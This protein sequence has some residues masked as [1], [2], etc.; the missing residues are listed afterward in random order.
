MQR[1]RLIAAV[2]ILGVYLLVAGIFIIKGFSGTAAENWTQ[3]M[4]VFN[5][6]GALATTAAGVLFGADIQQGNV[7]EANRT[8]VEAAATT[9]RR[10]E[11]LRATLVALQGGQGIADP[12]AAARQQ[13]LSG[14]A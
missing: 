13:I 6:V 4:A 5:A 10:E 9:A 11:A 7:D 3:V 2:I 8:A 12:I 1:H 14:L